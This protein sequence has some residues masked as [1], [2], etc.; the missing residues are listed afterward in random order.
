MVL[1]KVIIVIFLSLA[2]VGKGAVSPQCIIKR[3]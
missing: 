2:L 3:N 1:C